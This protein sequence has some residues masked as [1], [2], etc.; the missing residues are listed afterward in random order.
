[1]INCGGMFHSLSSGNAI[2]HLASAEH[3]K[4]VKSFLWKYGGGMDRMD[5]FRISESDFTKVALPD[6]L[7][8]VLG[9]IM[10][11]ALGFKSWIYL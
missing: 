9:R 4:G 1:M 10:Y 5:S 8:F 6:F 3:L 11:F 7:P 2:A